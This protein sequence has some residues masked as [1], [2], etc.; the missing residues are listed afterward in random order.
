MEQIRYLTEEEKGRTR[1][2]YEQSFSDSK[3]FVDYYY[4][5]KIKE[6]K[7]LV[8]EK[9]GNIVS[10]AHRS[11]RMVSYKGEKRKVIYIYAVATDPLH[12]KKGYMKKILWKLLEDAKKEGF[13]FATLITENEAY[14]KK[15]GFCSY[16]KISE[17]T[18]YQRKNDEI[19]R[20][21]ACL[22][23]YPV[24]A[25]KA[26]EWLK[27]KRLYQIRDVAFYKE[28]QAQLEAEDGYLELLYHDCAFIGMEG[29]YY[30]EDGTL[31]EDGGIY[32]KG[33]EILDQRKKEKSQL[34]ICL[35]KE[36]IF[37]LSK[38][39]IFLNELV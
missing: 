19:I 30:E 12:R 33:W 16:G 39:S 36:K 38:E 20:K 24:M 27:D 15:L 3:K 17:P 9:D 29:F 14:Y 28:Y 37:D 10:M 26:L 18:L 5:V 35:L 13:A 8:L 34:M 7:V 32:K 1:R 22:N 21:K 11:T 2:L 31:M 6:N 23:D 25:E 4:A